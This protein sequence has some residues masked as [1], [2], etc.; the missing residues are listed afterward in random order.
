LSRLVERAANGEPFI[1]AKTGK[2]LVK[3][4]PLDALAEDQKSSR[5]GFPD[6]LINVPDDFKSMESCHQ[7]RFGVAPI[8]ASIRACCATI[9]C[10]TVTLNCR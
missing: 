6:G 5:I 7:V 2:P 8:S 4:V 1:I 9:C 3:V 10:A